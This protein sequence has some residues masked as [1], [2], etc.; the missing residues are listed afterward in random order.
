MAIFSP[1]GDTEFPW[2]LTVLAKSS[3]CDNK[4]PNNHFLISFRE[5]LSSDLSHC[6]IPLLRSNAVLQQTCLFTVHLSLVTVQFYPLTCFASLW[7]RQWRGHALL[8]P[9]NGCSPCLMSLQNNRPSIAVMAKGLFFLKK[10]CFAGG[11]RLRRV[12]ACQ[13]CTGMWGYFI[14][15]ISS[16]RRF[17]HSNFVL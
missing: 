4:K 1:N 13:R 8:C 10:P 12:M 14:N 7:R 3:L 6:L 2:V 5:L 16:L 9:V 17:L 11:S 15:T